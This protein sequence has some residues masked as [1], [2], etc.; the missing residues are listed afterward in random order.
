MN[1]TNL[2]KLPNNECR[3][4]S[5][6][7][8]FGPNLKVYLDPSTWCIHGNYDFNDNF[9]SSNSEVLARFVQLHPFIISWFGDSHNSSNLSQ[10]F[11]KIMKITSLCSPNLLIICGDIVNGSGEYRGIVENSWFEK[12]WNFIKKLQLNNLWIKGNHDIDPNC[13]YYYLWF[14]RLWTFNIGRYKLIGFDTFNEEKLVPHTSYAFISLLDSLW[15]RNRLIEDDRFK[16][17]ISHHPLD[18]WFFRALI[19]FRDAKNI[20]CALA[21]HTHDSLKT[22]ISNIPCYINGTASPEVKKPLA[23]FLICFKNGEIHSCLLSET[24]NLEEDEDVIEIDGGMVLN[25]EKEVTEKYIPLRIVKY[26][27]DRYIS[28]IILHLPS[29][30]SRV[31]IKQNDKSLY[32]SST[33]QLYLIGKELYSDAFLYDGWKCSC[34]AIWNCYYIRANEKTFIKLI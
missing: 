29:R 13:Y 1:F 26:L 6:A 27:N 12:T 23:S 19:A 30:K 10:N 5:D 31:E 22:I 21:G 24:I 32:I 34:G 11:E 3:F 14:E 18:E 9:I 7:I 28:F 8:A 16:I 4:I 20:K 25:W 33:Q 2:H 15:L 17:I